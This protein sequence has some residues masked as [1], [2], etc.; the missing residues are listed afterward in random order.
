M[1][2]LP[3]TRSGGGSPPPKPGAADSWLE[4]KDDGG[5]SELIIGTNG[6]GAGEHRRS[7]SSA[8]RTSSHISSRRSSPKPSPGRPHLLSSGD[9]ETSPS[10]HRGRGGSSSSRQQQSAR[11]SSHRKTALSLNDA[12][13]LNSGGAAAAAAAPATSRSARPA[14]PS[15]RGGGSSSGSGSDSLGGSTA[16]GG[17]RRQ[18]RHPRSSFAAGETAAGEP[19]LTSAGGKVRR[20]S[21][22]ERGGG[23]G[24]VG[25]DETASA[26]RARR[27][28]EA[29]HARQLANAALQAA[30]AR[31]LASAALQ[32]VYA[33]TGGPR[34]KR[35]HWWLAPGSEVRLWYGAGVERG[36]LTAL[37]LPKNGLRGALPPSLGNLPT[38][39]LLDLSYNRRLGGELPACL[40]A[41]AQL[42]QQ[43]QRRQQQRQRR[44]AAV[45][46]V[47]GASWLSQEN[48]VAGEGE[49]ARGRYARSAAAVVWRPGPYYLSRAGKGDE[50][51]NLCGCDFEGPLPESLG[52]L[53]QLQELRLSGNRLSGGLPTSWGSLTKLQE[54]HVSSN[55]LD[56]SIPAPLASVVALDPVHA[57]PNRMASLVALD[58]SN[59]KL[60]GVVPEQLG[61]LLSLNL[62]RLEGNRLLTPLPVADSGPVLQGKRRLTPLPSADSGPVL[63]AWLR[64]LA[65]LHKLLAVHTVGLELKLKELQRTKEE[66]V[67]RLAVV[68]LAVALERSRRRVRQLEAQANGGSAAEAPAPGHQRRRSRGRQP[69]PHAAPRANNFSFAGSDDGALTPSRGASPSLG[70]SPDSVGW[71]LQLPEPPVPA[72]AAQSTAAGLLLVEAAVRAPR[73]A[74]L[75]AAGYHKLKLWCLVQPRPRAHFASAVLWRLREALSRAAAVEPGFKSEGEASVASRGRRGSIGAVARLQF[76]R[77]LR[78]ALGRRRPEDDE[79]DQTIGGRSVASGSSLGA[80]SHMRNRHKN[81]NSYRCNKSTRHLCSKV[82]QSSE[83]TVGGR[84]VAS[85]VSLGASSHTRGQGGA[86]HTDGEGARKRR[87]RVKTLP[88]NLAAAADETFDETRKGARW[89]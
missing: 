38:L 2:S 11:R 76:Q 23:G 33:A 83:P 10:P 69:T 46:V 26:A 28:R 42:R 41:L 78:A 7:L 68:R 9:E 81:L 59:N 84:S 60:E 20:R 22:G 27:D 71:E 35:A 66:E 40:G 87:G 47:A 54:L 37:R 85:G 17:A 12:T 21:R 58:L 14:T 32:D 16:S 63:Q 82:I 43:R 55:E 45:G 48:G 52:R 39:V 67:V 24:S 61:A 50:F 75:S 72:A 57:Y 15:D 70:A 29:A 44:R 6:H 13:A 56:G 18:Q 65:W 88:A 31:Q 74:A 49:I 34:W 4:E 73:I 77:K 19:L 64:K 5:P 80:S 1:D 8:S 62:L 51:L 53:S 86:Y 25:G 36:A 30:H 79:D 89:E 3:S